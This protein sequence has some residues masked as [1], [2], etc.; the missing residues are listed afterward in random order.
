MIPARGLILLKPVQT[1]ETF[2]GSPIVLLETTR[3]RWTGFQT[4]PAIGN[5]TK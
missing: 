1:A 5:Y 4:P 2:A 3:E